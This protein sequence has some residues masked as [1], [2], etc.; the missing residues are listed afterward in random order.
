M[1]EQIW[2]DTRELSP[3][4]A[5]Q[6]KLWAMQLGRLVHET[7]RRAL[8]GPGALLTLFET[9]ADRF[10][11][12]QENLA[13]VTPITNF[14]VVQNYKKALVNRTK[15]RHGGKILDVVVEA[16][17]DTSLDKDSQRLGASPNIVHSL[18]ATHLMLVI[19]RCDFDVAP[20]HDSFGCV[21]GNMSS[22]FRKTRETFVELYKEDPLKSILTQLG[23]LDL[24]PERGTY[25]VEEILESDYAFS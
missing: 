23:S 9:L 13:W 10:N 7:S 20:I 14:P 25:N 21:A 3:Y 16:W 8:T 1:G 15:M 19:D 5:R 4:L 2:E 17:D 6:E 12:K 18:D 22:L 11:D 24:M